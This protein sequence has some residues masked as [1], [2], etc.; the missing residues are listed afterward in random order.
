M[1]ADEIYGVTERI[2]EKSPLIHSITN[3]ISINQC[4]NALLA[5]GARP[6]MAEHPRE[7][8]EI[9]ETADALYLNLGNITDARMESM[10]ISVKTAKEKNIPVTLDLVG[11]ACSKLRRDYASEL[12]G[13]N[14]PT[15][16]KGNYS[17]ITAMSQIGYTS[18]GVDADGSLTMESVTKTAACLADK[19]NTVVLASGKTDIIC[20]GGRVLYA[21]NGTPQLSRVTGTGCILGALAACCT[22]VTDGF[23]AAVSACALLGISGELS[24]TDKG[25]GSFMVNL[26]DNLTTL[27]AER[28]KERLNIEEAAHGKI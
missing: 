9:T 24:E 20:G 10:M 4:A 12:I 2:R 5:V 3:P 16:I 25:G 23:D 18:A 28:I 19:F 7:V 17:E 6:I 13:A 11:A 14:V 8:R 1:K 21:H 26:I 15:I 22:A 27:N